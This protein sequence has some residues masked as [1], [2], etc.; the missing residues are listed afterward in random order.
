MVASAGGG[1]FTGMGIP[2]WGRWGK[3]RDMVGRGIGRGEG[4]GAGS[5]SGRGLGLGLGE[6]EQRIGDGMYGLTGTVR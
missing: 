1:L 6:G 2:V 5:G 3:G 4:S